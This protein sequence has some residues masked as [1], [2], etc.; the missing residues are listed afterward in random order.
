MVPSWA[1]DFWLSGIDF[2][3]DKKEIWSQAPLTYAHEDIYVE[4]VVSLGA[5]YRDLGLVSAIIAFQKTISKNFQIPPLF[6]G[7]CT[8]RLCVTL[9]RQRQ[10]KTGDLLL[11]LVT[12]SFFMVSCGSTLWLCWC[13]S[14]AS[15]QETVD[16]EHGARCSVNASWLLLVAGVWD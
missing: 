12:G 2:Y 9:Q 10:M 6:N 11:S 7:H 15:W 5:M 14:R 8:V 13:I 16:G 4:D 3:Q 1:G